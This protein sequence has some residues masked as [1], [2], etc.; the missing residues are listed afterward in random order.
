MRREGD[1]VVCFLRLFDGSRV[2]LSFDTSSRI[3]LMDFKDHVSRMSFKEFKE[4]V[5]ALKN[6][7]KYIEDSE[8]GI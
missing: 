2:D 5:R 1:R 4:F 6:C 3:V 7:I 8:E